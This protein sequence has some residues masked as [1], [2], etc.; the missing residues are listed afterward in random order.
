MTGRTTKTPGDSGEPLDSISPH[1]TERKGDPLRSAAAAPCPEGSETDQPRATPW[2]DLGAD[3]LEV[4]ALLQEEVARLEQ[5]LR[6]QD[7][8]PV[9]P[10]AK[11]TTSTPE[12]IES[13]AAEELAV[14]RA[15]IERLEAELGDREETISLLLDQLSRVEEAQAASRAEWEQVAGWLAELEQRVEGQDGER[16]APCSGPDSEVVEVLRS[17]NLRLRTAWEELSQRPATEPSETGAAGLAE[18]RKERDALRR[19]L[20]QL[21]DEK[22]REQHEHTAAL[23]ELQAQLSRAALARPA[24]PTPETDPGA[25]GLCRQQD[26]D[27]RF[28]ALRQHLL[29]IHQQEA[30]ERKQK[31][32]IPRLSRLWSRTGP[33]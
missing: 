6:R 29:E 13:V 16:G 25:E 19:Q 10:T 14:A 11:G 4:I 26:V 12:S 3:Y 30:Q 5:E 8:G 7:Q 28:R 33:R 32:L 22:R 24:E 31:Q 21:Q 1:Q 18:T 17:E 2:E 27:L 9:E 20:E 23:V 15:T